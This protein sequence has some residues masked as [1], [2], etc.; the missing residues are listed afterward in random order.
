LKIFKTPSEKFILNEKIRLMRLKNAYR[1]ELDKLPAGTIQTLNLGGKDLF[2]L[3]QESF[4]KKNA[5]SLCHYSMNQ[6]DELKAKISRR[7]ELE[8][9]LR[10]ITKEL[11]RIERALNTDTI[12]E[13]I[14]EL[15][16]KNWIV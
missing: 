8:R 7:D 13:W 16:A 5:K 10:S 3:V 14:N 6:L 11:G 15:K 9:E 12:E 4:G 2:Y 1:H